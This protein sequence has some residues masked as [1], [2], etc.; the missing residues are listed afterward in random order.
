MRNLKELI[1]IVLVMLFLP[2]IHVQSQVRTK[3]T[4]DG[5]PDEK[6][7]GA[8]EAAAATFLTSCNTS[9]HDKKDVN[10]TSVAISA[11]ARKSFGELWTNTPFECREA[12]IDRSL[13][14]REYDHTYEIRN[15]PIDVEKDDKSVE[16]EECVLVFN[17]SGEIEQVLFAIDSQK[18]AQMLAHPEDVKDLRLR[19]MILNF[20]E[21]FRT[22][23]NRKDIVFLEDVFSDNALIIVG[24]VVQQTAVSS[25]QYL[26]GIENRKVEYIRKGKMEYMRDLRYAFK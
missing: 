21:N 26:T 24:R 6:T 9:F 5:A 16:S 4:V 15:I 8:I 19:Q 12:D 23:Y 14:E 10:L 17:G 22:A 25:D 20:V 3:V 2:T 13:I 1:C 18:Y 7:K 11:D